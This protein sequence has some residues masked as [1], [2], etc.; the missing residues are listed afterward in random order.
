VKDVYQLRPRNEQDGP[1]IANL[2]ANQERAAFGR[3]FTTENDL[4]PSRPRFDPAVDSWVVTTPDGTVVAYGEV[5]ERYPGRLW[6]ALWVT[7]E[8]HAGG[9]LEALLLDL[10]EG[11]AQEATAGSRATLR[12]IIPSS[13][14]RAAHL[15]L[16][17]GYE[18]VRTFQH[19][20]IDL[21][22]GIAGVAPVAGVSI[23]PFDVARDEEAFHAALEAAFED[24]WEFR[25]T[26][27]PQ[28]RES[29]IESPAFDAGLWF[30][31]ENNDGVIGAVYA[32][33]RPAGGWIN[34]LGVLR[35]YRGRGIGAALMSRAFQ[36]LRDRGTDHVE[37]NV[38]AGNPTGAARLYERLGMSVIRAWGLYDKAIG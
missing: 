20:A 34:D 33:T 19:M 14:D 3:A 18:R 5:W 6:E 12:N 15:L 25:P 26:P 24:T 23:R 11:R 29:W 1:T 17:S 9:E 32:S 28:W 37:L 4:S 16:E 27:F 22:S 38:D 2:F 31:A 10:T 36:A 13:D 21:S 30:V 7:T 35:A 8:T